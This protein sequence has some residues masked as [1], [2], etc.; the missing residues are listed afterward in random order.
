MP[1]ENEHNTC[2]ACVTI[3]FVMRMEKK[4]IST[5]LICTIKIYKKKK[6]KTTN[7]IMT[8]LESDSELESDIELELKS[9]LESDTE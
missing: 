6:K 7:F 4:K 8:E 5:G 3:E 1:K 2:I 9:E